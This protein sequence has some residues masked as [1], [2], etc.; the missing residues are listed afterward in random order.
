MQENQEDK[1]YTPTIEELH[2]GYCCEIK[3]WENNW[4]PF[5]L[6]EVRVRDNVY[7]SEGFLS[8]LVEQG[9]V[10]TLFLTKEQIEVEGWEYVEG[11]KTQIFKTFVGEYIEDDDC[12][13]FEYKMYYIASTHR[14]SIDALT[15]S[16]GKAQ[17]SCYE[18]NC[19]LIFRGEIKSINELKTLMKWLKIK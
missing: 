18:G 17:Y 5:L 6:K 19:D 16:Y 13:G 1:Y 7:S 11:V 8:D 12:T 4:I 2:V 15:I 3:D 10:R 14:M 9:K